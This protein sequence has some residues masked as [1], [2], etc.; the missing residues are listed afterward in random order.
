MGGKPAA[1]LNPR[2]PL[3]DRCP[4]RLVQDYV[5]DPRLPR[6]NRRKRVESRPSTAAL[7]SDGVV[8]K[9]RPSLRGMGRIAPRDNPVYCVRYEAASSVTARGPLPNGTPKTTCYRKSRSSDPRTADLER[10]VSGN[11]TRLAAFA[12]DSSIAA[13]KQSLLFGY[14][15][16]A[17][18]Q[19]RSHRP[20]SLEKSFG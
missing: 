5:S 20:Q 16:S 4:E 2:A 18:P 19:S 15:R 17:V 7:L 6:R 11:S 3:L 10:T 8:P 12:L 13:R 14:F 9:T 1:G